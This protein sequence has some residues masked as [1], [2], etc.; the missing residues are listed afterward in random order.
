MARVCNA[1]KGVCATPYSVQ[2][3]EHRIVVAYRKQIPRS[4]TEGR[5]RK[6]KYMNL[7]SYFQRFSV[8]RIKDSTKEA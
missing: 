2:D 7:V 5:L 1:A 3:C 6:L 4:F 8:R